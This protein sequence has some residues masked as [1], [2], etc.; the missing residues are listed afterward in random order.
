MKKAV[1][2]LLVSFI[3]LQ[4]NAQVQRP[5]IDVQSFAEEIFE[6]QDEDI[7]YEDLYESLL[8][9]YTNPINLNSA[10]RDDLIS[11]Y[12][13]EPIQIEN[14]FDYKESNGPLLSIYELQAVP[15]FDVTTI[16]KILPFVSLEE[17]P[18]DTRSLWQRIKEEENNYLLYRMERTLEKQKGYSEPELNSSGEPETRYNGGRNKHYLR[19]RVSRSKDFSFG[20][21]M[22]KDAGEQF[23]FDKSSN[24]YGVDFLSFH[25]ML[26]NKGRLKSIVIGD[27]QLQFGQG[28][29]LGAGFNPGK[30]SET[31]TTI[32]RSS[33]GV[34][35]YSSVLETGFYRGIA[36]TYNLNSIDITG[37]YSNHLQDAN[38]RNDSTFTEFDEFVSSIQGS[39]FHRTDSEIRNKDQ[40]R[41]QAVGVNVTYR[42]PNRQFQSGITFMN[43][44]YDVALFKTPNTYNQF[45]F[46]GRSNY[47]VGL[48][49]NYVWQNLNFFGETA[50][51]KSGGIGSV[52][53]VVA[54]LSSQLSMS[55]VLRNYQKDFHSFYGNAFGEGSRNINE[56]GIYWGLKFAPIRRIIVT[57]YY[58]YFRFPWLRFG[59]EGPSEGNE[60]LIRATYKPT[61][62]LVLY[63]QLRKETKERNLLSEGNLQLLAEGVKYNYLLNLDYDATKVFSM[64]SRLQWSSFEFDSEL[65][66]GF[67][68]IQDFNFDFGK[69]RLST[70]FALFDTDDFDNR[71]FAYEKDVLYAF[72]IPAYNGVGIRNYFL[73]QY[74]PTRKITVW[75]RLARSVRNDVDTFGSGLNEIN[76]DHRTDLKLQVRFMF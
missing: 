1:I 41:E 25:A 46:Q 54:S 28:L 11:L 21:T 55:V 70:R 60:Y 69:I 24:T 61:R 23:Q 9:L 68:I 22:E 18:S 33:T 53:G 64:K 10:T 7:N 6:F 37:F 32:R 19:Y 5:E 40:V 51:S 58:D 8:L 72:S 49:G 50:I 12:A 20:F 29:L 27:Y 71:Q 15:G 73:I 38:I 43:T 3:C 65:T 14:F 44:A 4:A 48:F 36:A 16:Q 74:K 67:A 17:R 76:A 47:N 35:A 62:K 39:G 26:E 34:R 59:V 31:I 66:R 56:R 13:L 45:E 75:A 42:S 2:I 63:G 52:G 57:A 30:G